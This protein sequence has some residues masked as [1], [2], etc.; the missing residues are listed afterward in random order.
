MV[1]CILGILVESRYPTRQELVGLV[2]LT[3]G[4]MLAVWQVRGKAVTCMRNLPGLAAP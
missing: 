2:I 4:V 3:F 1:A